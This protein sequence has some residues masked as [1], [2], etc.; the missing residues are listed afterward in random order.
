MV[1]RRSKQ[2]I[3]PQNRNRFILVVIVVDITTNESMTI[4]QSVINVYIRVC[5]RRVG[6]VHFFCQTNFIEFGE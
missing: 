4:A 2:F 5:V 3:W 1:N 6:Y